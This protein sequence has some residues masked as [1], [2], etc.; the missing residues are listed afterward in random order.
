MKRHWANRD[1]ALGAASAR[2]C[3]RTQGR[4]SALFTLTDDKIPDR[5]ADRCA[6]L[7]RKHDNRTGCYRGQA[8]AGTSVPGRA[9]G[10]RFTVENTYLNPRSL[11]FRARQRRFRLIQ[12]LIEKIIAEKGSC[13][14]ADT[15][16]Y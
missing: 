1:D 9:T 16:Y 15:E 3:L 2:H 5:R 4:L 14:I 10:G 6:A 13:R 11:S 8:F 7:E 12:P